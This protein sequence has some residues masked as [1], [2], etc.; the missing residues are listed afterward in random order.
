MA[1]FDARGFL[2]TLERNLPKK[3]VRNYDEEPRL[4]KVHVGI[5]ENQGKY[6]VLVVPGEKGAPMTFLK[7]VREIKIPRTIQNEDG[8]SREIGIWTRIL[9]PDAYT[10]L[11]ADGQVV[12]SL[13]ASDEDLLGRVQF[14]FDTLYDLLGGNIRGA[15]RSN[16]DMNKAS[17]TMRRKNYSLFFG[18]ALN[19]WGMD[20]P[21]NPKRSNFPALFIVPAAA[22]PEA[23][24]NNISDVSISYGAPETW[25]EQIYNRQ[26]SGRTGFLLFSASLGTGAQVGYSLSIQHVINN[27]SVSSAV[28]PEEDLALM[29][30]P[31]EYFLGSFQAAKNDNGDLIFNRKAMEEVL[32]Y[33]NG[34]IAAI[35]STQGINP[36]MAAGVTSG[37]AMSQGYGQPVPQTNDPMLHQY[38]QPGMTN[39]GAVFTNNVDPMRTPPAAQIDPITQ[40]PVEA[41]APFSSPNFASGLPF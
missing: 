20:D 21:R 15:D 19:H 30:D 7:R 37:M 34:Q 5:P 33:M 9:G 3:R 27:Q 25:L 29:K 23:V 12:S 41:Q 13:T 28:I 2:S 11:S 38:S 24:D 4:K 1:N 40:A 36:A 32:E 17:S 16:P 10:M 6:Q 31:I 35:R 39:P 14:A 26:T 22:F 18:Y 8:T